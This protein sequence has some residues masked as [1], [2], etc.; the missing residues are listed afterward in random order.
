MHSIRYEC[1]GTVKNISKDGTHQSRFKLSTFREPGTPVSQHPKTRTRQ[2]LNNLVNA[3]IYVDAT[4][5]QARR[6]QRIYETE[7]VPSVSAWNNFHDAPQQHA[8]FQAYEEAKRAFDE[9]KVTRI[10]EGRRIPET[11]HTDIQAF[12]DDESLTKFLTER[13]DMVPFSQYCRVPNETVQAE[14]SWSVRVKDHLEAEEQALPKPKKIKKSVTTRQEYTRESDPCM[15]P[16]RSGEGQLPDSV[17]ARA[18][19]LEHIGTR[20]VQ[21]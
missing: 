5:N 21:F 12:L 10:H 6:M 2:I 11:K 3:K 18:Q 7:N 8:R 4:H 15:A 17:S 14:S 13:N 1:V 16:T 20:N 9:F 19:G